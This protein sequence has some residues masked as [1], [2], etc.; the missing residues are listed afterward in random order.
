MTSMGPQ[1]H[2]KCHSK[3]QREVAQMLR[4][5]GDGR[6]EA[7]RGWSDAAAGLGMPGRPPEARRDEG[8]ILP[9]A[10]RGT[11]GLLDFGVGL[12]E[13]QGNKCLLF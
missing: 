13:L 10:P 5:E 7:D 11:A 6:M 2:H 4:G 1:C 3:K 9:S 12:P 8:C